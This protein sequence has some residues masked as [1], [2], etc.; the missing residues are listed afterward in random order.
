MHVLE[1]DLEL[2]SHPRFGI[3]QPVEVSRAL[4]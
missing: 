4:D 1:L 3:V 2:F